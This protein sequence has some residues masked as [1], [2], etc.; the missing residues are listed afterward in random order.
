MQPDSER[1]RAVASF[2][3]GDYQQAANRLVSLLARTP[4]DPLLLRLCGMALVR[5][6]EPVRGLPYLARA[7]RLAPGQPLPALW[8]GIA[9]H[10]S[11]RFTDAVAALQASVVAAPVD[12][13]PL[14]HLSRALLK[15]DLL[16]D[17][18]TTA[19]AAV[20]LAPT[21]LEA[22]HALRLADLL[23]RQAAS[24]GD[25]AAVAGAWFDLG[26]VCLRLDNVVEAKGA[27]H[28]ALALR[29]DDV[30]VA[31]WLAMVEHLCG[32]P[33]TAVTRL[34][35]AVRCQPGAVIPRL[36]LA[37]RLM[38]AGDA[39]EALALLD[40]ALPNEP[41]LQARWQ[42]WRIVALM[43]LGRDRDAEHI[44]AG[45][46]M[47]P[48]AAE[49]IL[50]WQQILLARRSGN[51]AT[52]SVLVNRVAQLAA[53]RERS[54]P[55]DRLDAHFRLA[56]LHVA[57]GRHQEAFRHWQCGHALL[58]RAQPFSRPAHVAL[59]GAVMGA[60]DRSRMTC[61]RKADNADPSPVFIVG[62]PR[63]GTTLVEQILSSH[64]MVHG[65]GERLAVREA[66]QSLVGTSDAAKAAVRAAGLETPRLTSAAN[67]FLHAL[68]S[69]APDA[70]YVLDKMPDNVNQLGFIA[71][72]LPA[73]RVICCTRDLRDVGISI[74]Q[75]RF[76]GY[77]PYAHDLADLGWY[78]ARHRR[79][80]E[81]WRAVLPIRMLELD[82]AEWIADADATLSRMLAFLDLPW[83]D[84]CKR[85]FEQTRIVRTAS[86]MQVRE[87]I[88]SR[89][90]GRWRPFEEQLTP[91]LREL[92][93]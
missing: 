21:M 51:T 11:G 9:L 70:R 37:S 46:T 47:P 85:F 52:V 20:T 33:V 27:L 63:T 42:A 25:P 39:G 45:M 12:P 59:H 10:A 64:P 79:L 32:E 13:A 73:A 31:A 57:E 1:D 77:H 16:T 54:E 71:T 66:L 88:N 84:R 58:Q 55:E 90:V 24:P 76:L 6:G 35:A 48:G 92:A 61:D 62:L 17:A 30:E 15:L 75:Q 49:I 74:F 40:A 60:F 82:H 81:H 72:L 89:G 53:D 18:R 22:H 5:M 86:A 87:P 50:R 93:R 41:A 29:P 26:L 67:T 14:I 78:M 43:A 65:A 19:A 23:A 91:M 83:D 56:G 36:H 28:Q 38:L 68:H 44:L 80:L 3:A 2:E 4:P 69:E 8:H 7:R 34:R